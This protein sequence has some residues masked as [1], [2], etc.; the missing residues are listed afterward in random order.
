MMAV[1]LEREA[2]VMEQQI[3]C[4]TCGIVIR[5][6]P[7]IVDGQPYCC[8]GCAQGGPCTCDY[9]NLPQPGKASPMAIRTTHDSQAPN[10]QS[11]NAQDKKD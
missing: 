6:Q 10:S 3:V 2:G 11:G 1:Y 4:V 7:T 8:P 5:W 9:D